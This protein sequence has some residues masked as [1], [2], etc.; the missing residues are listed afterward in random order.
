MNAYPVQGANI[1]QTLFKRNENLIVPNDSISDAYQNLSALSGINSMPQELN[2]MQS[3]MPAFLSQA[4][5]STYFQDNPWNILEYSNKYGL[6][7][8]GGNLDLSQ[9]PGY[10]PGNIMVSARKESFE[11]EKIKIH[12]K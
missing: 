1:T 5:L 4:H 12:W 6:P 2:N 7:T 3:Q 11:N 10:K 8:M 9:P